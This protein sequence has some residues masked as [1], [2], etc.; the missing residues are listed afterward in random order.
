MLRAEMFEKFMRLPDF[1]KQNFF[2]KCSG[3]RN[4]HTIL[5]LM[6]EALATRVAMDRRG[7]A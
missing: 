6:R 7:I 1:R 4:A 2:T 5:D 3:I